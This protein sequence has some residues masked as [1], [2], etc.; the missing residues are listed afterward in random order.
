MAHQSLK[1][2]R[3]IVGLH[4]CFTNQEAL[5]ASLAQLQDGAGVLQAAFGYLH[6][7]IRNERRQPGRGVHVGHEGAQVA[8]VHAHQIDAV[9]EVAAQL[10]FVVHFEQHFQPQRV[11][12]LAELH[13][14]SR[15]QAR[16]D[17]QNQVGAHGTR[18]SYLVL[19]DDKILAQNRRVR[20]GC[21]RR[22]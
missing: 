11:R 7:R 15:A 5:V 10:V 21:P 9:G 22:S 13:H 2:R 8:V 18:L 16:G 1:R 3:G 20:V 4:E 6:E 17:E 14:L 19:A 12:K